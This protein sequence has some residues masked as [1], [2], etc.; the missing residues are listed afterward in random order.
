MAL[1]SPDGKAL[2]YIKSNRA[3][4]LWK[5]PVEGGEETQVLASVARRSFAVVDG[6]IY[7]ISEPSSSSGYLIQY[8]SLPSGRIDPV[9]TIGKR[10]PSGFTVSPDRQWFVYSQADP[11]GSDLMLVENFR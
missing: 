5:I 4:S 11:L 2:Y 6:G 8:Y 1:E 7:F 3:G 10:W 9:A